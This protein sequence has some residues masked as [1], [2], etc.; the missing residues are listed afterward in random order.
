M[1]RS[2]LRKE[3]A[4][5]LDGFDGWRLEAR[6]SPGAS[7]LWCFVSGGKVECSVSVESAV[8]HLYVMETD[9]EMTFNSGDSLVA[10]LGVHRPDAVRPAPTRAARKKRVSK[11]FEWS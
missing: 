5:L 8:M 4:E 10:W 9:D 7:P 1:A 2:S 11:F 6:T 3:L